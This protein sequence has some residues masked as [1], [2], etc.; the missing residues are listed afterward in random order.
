MEQLLLVN[1]RRR[2]RRSGRRMPAGL[3]RYWATHRAGRKRTRLANPRRRR[4]HRRAVMANPRRRRRRYANPRRRHHA[5]RYR[6]PRRGRS[7]G[8][9]SLGVQGGLVQ[10]ALVPGALGAAGALTLDVVMGYASPYLPVTLQTGWFNV[11]VKGAAAIGVG[12]L[13]GK[14]LGRERGKVAM[15]GG[16]T[17]VLYGALKTLLTS[18][19]VTLPGLSG[20]QDYTPYR[21][22]AYM[23]GATGTPGIAGLGRLGYVSP[24]ATLGSQ[25]MLSPRMG[26]YMPRSP[27]NVAPQMG[28]YGDNM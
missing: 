12:M 9:L 18:S 17:V 14:F 26:A 20:Y 10:G 13:V 28:D 23:P 5:R 22:G 24:A 15:L 16:L 25:A 7:G 8:R 4:R 1:P 11:A 27:M 21:M 19:G 2:K 3:A 6:N